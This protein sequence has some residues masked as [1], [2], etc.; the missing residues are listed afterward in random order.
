[1]LVGNLE[2]GKS[3][4]NFLILCERMQVVSACVL[5]VL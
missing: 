5:L 3:C 2:G 4:N 1:M